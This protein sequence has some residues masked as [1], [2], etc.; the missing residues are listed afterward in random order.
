MKVKT[1]FVS[2]EGKPHITGGRK[3]FPGHGV[4]SAFMQSKKKLDLCQRLRWKLMIKAVF[5]QVR[6]GPVMC[7]QKDLNIMH[8]T[9]FNN[10]NLK[11]LECW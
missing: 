6:S 11:G 1:T 4:D 2:V 7:R 8:N 10:G 3:V 9:D 5:K